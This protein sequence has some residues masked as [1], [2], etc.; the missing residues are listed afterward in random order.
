MPRGVFQS[1]A[2]VL[3]PTGIAAGHSTVMVVNDDAGYLMPRGV[4]RSIASVLAP[5]GIAAGHSTVGASMLAMV[6]NDDAGYLMPR[7]VFQSIASVLAP[8]GIAAGH[9]TNDDVGC[10]MP[11]AVHAPSFRGSISSATPGSGLVFER[12]SFKHVQAG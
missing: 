11:R 6:A 8:T 10:V 9:S 12:I 5:T 4:F 1:I 7:G 2:S 3:A